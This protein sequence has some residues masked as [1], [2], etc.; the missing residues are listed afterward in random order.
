[1]IIARV[2]GTVVTSPQ[3]PAYRG[4]KLLVVRPEKLT[5]DKAEKPGE[6]FLAIDFVQAG[7]GDRVLVIREGSST[8]D[9]L[10]DKMAPIHASI[11]GIVD[12]VHIETER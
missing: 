8:R 3:H 11:V 1:M 6:S 10:G 2:L 4:H 12:E 7:R 5:S 9:L